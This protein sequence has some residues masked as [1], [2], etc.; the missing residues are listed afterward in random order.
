MTR[1]TIYARSPL[2]LWRSYIKDL[3][4]DINF[5]HTASEDKKETYNT[6]SSIKPGRAGRL[7]FLLCAE[8][9]IIL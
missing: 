6:V 2:Y 4:F 8:Y 9:I 1:Y 3:K 7:Y 5:T